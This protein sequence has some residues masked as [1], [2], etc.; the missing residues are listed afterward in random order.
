MWVNAT[1]ADPENIQTYVAYVSSVFDKPNPT[2]PPVVKT[3]FICF[4]IRVVFG[5]VFVIFESGLGLTIFYIATFLELVLGTSVLPYYLYSYRYILDMVLVY[6]SLVFRTRV[7]YNYLPTRIFD[8]RN[9]LR[10]ED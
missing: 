1:T 9:Q 7:M 10:R 8:L 4:L 6:L 3:V 5:C 2:S